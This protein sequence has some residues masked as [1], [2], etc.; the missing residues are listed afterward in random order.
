[1]QL[2]HHHGAQDSEDGLAATLHLIPA[3]DDYTSSQV[4]PRLGLSPFHAVEV[5]AKAAQKASKESSAVE[6]ERA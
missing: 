3:N 2:I 4:F 6:H 5:E 1:M